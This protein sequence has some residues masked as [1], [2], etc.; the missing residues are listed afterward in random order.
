MIANEKGSKI[1][2]LDNEMDILK[3]GHTQGKWITFGFIARNFAA[4]V[5]VGIIVPHQANGKC[6]KKKF[7]LNLLVCVLLFRAILFGRILS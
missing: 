2:W 4:F 1:M 6:C 7:F 3:M 5:L